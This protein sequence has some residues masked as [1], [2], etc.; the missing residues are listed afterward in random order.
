MTPLLG[1]TWLFG[2]LSP[3]HKTFA[4]IFTILNSTQVSF[5][6]TFFIHLKTFLLWSD[7]ICYG[8]YK[9]R[10]TMIKLRKK[11]KKREKYFLLLFCHS[12][13]LRGYMVW[14]IKLNSLYSKILK[15]KLKRKQTK[16][17][18]PLFY[19]TWI[20]YCLKK[21]HWK[22]VPLSFKGFLIF[23]LHCV[24]NGQVSLILKE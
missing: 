23:I 16:K 14:L 21:W 15:Q 3:A 4:Y 5:S 18:K 8:N 22:R 19:L 13:N 17:T 24:R 20:A 11:K 10:H 1:V 2:L 12:R 9:I 7:D 6:P